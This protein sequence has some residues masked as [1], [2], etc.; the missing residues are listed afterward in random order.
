MWRG[1]R[2]CPLWLLLGAVGLP[3]PGRGQCNTQE[4][5]KLVASN[6]AAADYF[7]VSVALDADTLVIGAYG[8]DYGVD[9]TDSGAAYVF[10]RAA[11]V[12][13]QQAYLKP[14]N[15]ERFD[16]FGRAVSVSGDTVVVGAPI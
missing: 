9:T 7:G 4:V 16:S 12:W 10:V 13:S 15:T 3:Q 6:A 5:A 8:D 14:S 1:G 11:G 2:C